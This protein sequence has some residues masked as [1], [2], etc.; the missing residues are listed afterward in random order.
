MYWFWYSLACLHRS[1]PMKSPLLLPLHWSSED[2]K[3]CPSDALEVIVSRRAPRG[4]GLSNTVCSTLTFLWTVIDP[5]QDIW[6]EGMPNHHQIDSNSLCTLCHIYHILPHLSPER[7]PWPPNLLATCLTRH[8]K[9]GSIH[10]FSR[11]FFL[12]HTLPSAYGLHAVL[13]PL[14]GA[15]SASFITSLI[16]D[17]IAL[18]SVFINCSWA[19]VKKMFT[20]VLT[21]L[22][23][24]VQ[25]MLC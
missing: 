1:E 21:S 2:Q 14:T 18:D 7:S 19:Y 16:T 23:Y 8:L 3:W 13:G 5:E 24:I 17:S 6:S 11:Y 9:A 10:P 20:A 25:N 12:G 4:W 15:F 22:P